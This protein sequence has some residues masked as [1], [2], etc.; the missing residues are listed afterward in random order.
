M[1]FYMN[2]KNIIKKNINN[3]LVSKLGLGRGVDTNYFTKYSLIPTEIDNG[4]IEKVPYLSNYYF[5]NKVNTGD[6]IIIP[7]YLTDYY[8]SE[9]LYDD[10]SKRFTINY[11]LD[12]IYHTI[13]NVPAGDYELNVGSCS[14]EGEKTITIQVVDNL[15]RKSYKLFKWVLVVDPV[16]YPITA[17]QTYNVTQTDLTNHNIIPNAD[18]IE[19]AKLNRQG[20]Q[21]LLDEIKANGYRK[22][23]LLQDTYKID[24]GDNNNRENI[25]NIPDRFTL[26]LN[27]STIKLFYVAEVIPARMMTIED[28][29]D[30]HV[31]N[32]IFEG[33]Y[34]ER[35][36]NG[37]LKGWDSEGINCFS[38]S[39]NSRY[40]S[41]NNI[42]VKWISGYGCA[43]GGGGHKKGRIIIADVCPTF[44]PNTCINDVNGEEI[45]SDNKST[46]SFLDLTPM[47]ND[48]NRDISMFNYTYYGGTMGCD[49]FNLWYSYYDENY[50]FIDTVFTQMYRKTWIPENAKYLKLTVTNAEYTPDRMY[51]IVDM[52]LP[53]NCSYN[54][55]HAVE[56]RTCA[57]N[58]NQCL[59]FDLSD[60]T[61]TRCSCDTW[62]S[63]PTPVPI[64]IEDGWFLCNDFYFRNITIDEKSV[65]ASGGVIIRTGFNI[66]FENCS[67]LGEM[68]IGSFGTVMRNN[69]G[70]AVKVDNKSKT[71]NGYTRIYNNINISGGIA[72]NSDNLMIIKNC[73]CN[74]ISASSSI[75]KDCFFQFDPDFKD[76]IPS[77]SA[78]L[79][80]TNVDLYGCTIKGMN[81]TLY[82]VEGTN[83]YNC[84]F[85]NN[86]NF[87]L[88][89]DN[90]LNCYGC[91]I[92]NQEMR[93]TPAKLVLENCMINNLS[94]FMPTWYGSTANFTFNKCNITNDKR[95][96]FGELDDRTVLIENCNVILT[97]D[98]ALFNSDDIAR[99]III[100]INNV[101]LTLD[102]YLIDGRLTE[103]TAPTVNITSKNTYFVKG[104]YAAQSAID[105]RY[106]TINGGNY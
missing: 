29:F 61:M 100:K 103:T 53:V 87:D 74:N 76:T 35:R 10:T 43:T 16:T 18:T 41:F 34:I 68:A 64:D 63:N 50:N 56:T 9:Y 20:L 21:S 88:I 11:S 30:S 57:F 32:G 55:L 71:L 31:T 15:G 22:A 86:T 81:S 44:T 47:L 73:T 48:G 66:L 106:V 102:T 25:I 91:N 99:S 62:G 93:G 89:G 36:D 7:I 94:I 5:E 95:L 70:F 85:E 46:S 42:E 80:F 1:K 97:G 8:Q 84:T 49:N 69:R 54:H 33:D 75:Y 39:Q 26:D 60:I 58:P 77:G 51:Q 3:T 67:N 82:R 40:C 83:A 17:S 2:D 92:T 13:Q 65:N 19:Q 28:R 37:T 59:D 23:V 90:A 45:Y 12:G 4:E 24:H 38:I 27:G 52:P 79:A 14:T 98:N 104:S 72:K 105:N 78:H 101:S 6:D 96:I